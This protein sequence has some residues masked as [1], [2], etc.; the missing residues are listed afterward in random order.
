MTKL[1]NIINDANKH[2]EMF[3]NEKIISYSI[4][5]KWV[6]NLVWKA[7][8]KDNSYVVK[9]WERVKVDKYTLNILERIN[10]KSPKIITSFE[11]NHN[12][13]LVMQF[14][15]WELLSSHRE[16]VCIYLKELLENL[17]LLH[18]SFKYTWWGY[19]LDYTNWNLWEWK[20]FILKLIDS[21]SNN[22]N[23]DNILPNSHHWINI[24][25][26]TRQFLK[27]NLN[28]VSN[29]EKSSLLHFD[30]NLSNIII[31]NWKLESIIDW[32]DSRIWD[33]LYDFARLRLTLEYLW[34]NNL[35][36]YYYDYLN[37]NEKEKNLEQYYFYHIALE[38]VYHFNFIK[39]E[40]YVDKTLELLKTI[41]K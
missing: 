6:D 1:N 34:D 17:N 21:P 23:W 4:F 8:F 29:L 20:N 10:F 22:E 2:L 27:T 15:N 37:L 39:N 7:N 16:S 11:I 25:N 3:L 38:Y 32:S 18:K 36:K 9:V 41:N 40:K 5:E 12:E 24:I 28:I 33:P 30:T 26:N 14:I 19:V 13:C 31:K 35:I